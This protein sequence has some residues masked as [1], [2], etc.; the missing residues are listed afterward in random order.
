M[1]Y[2]KCVHSRVC[3]HVC[4]YGCVWFVRHMIICMQQSLDKKCLCVCVYVC[5]CVCV[6]VHVCMWLSV[7]LTV[8]DLPRIPQRKGGK[9]LSYVESL[10]VCVCVCVYVCVLVCVCVLRM[11][12][13]CTFHLALRLFFSDRDPI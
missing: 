3:I 4:V 9:V 5:E 1:S 2:L 6:C 10:C 12:V 13:S 8:S 11:C 7:T